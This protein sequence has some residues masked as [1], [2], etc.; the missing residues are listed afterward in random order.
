LLEEG[1]DPITVKHQTQAVPTFGELAEKVMNSQEAEFRNEKH[2]AQWRATMRGYAGPLWNLSVN[3]IE[4][5]NVLK[6]L[7]PIWT[8]KA[9]TA[10]RV[11]GRIERLSVGREPGALAWASTPSCPSDRSCS[12]VI[13]RRVA[14]RARLHCPL[15]RNR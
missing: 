5:D 4:T 7:Q 2:K 14:R 15:A 3:D 11:S 12:A 10:S 8:A 9:E 13:T 1:E 6:V